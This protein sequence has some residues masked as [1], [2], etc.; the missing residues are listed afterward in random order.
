MTLFM[1]EGEIE[2]AANRFYHHPV[3]GPATRSLAD[4]MQEVNRKSDGWPYWGHKAAAKLMALIEC[5]HPYSHDRHEPTAAEVR[6][7]YGPIKAF[8]T[9]KGLSFTGRPV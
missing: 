5:A 8:C 4:Y 9:K 2:E 3:L 6:K 7:A 1:N